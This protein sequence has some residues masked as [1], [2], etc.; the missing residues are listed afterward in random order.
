MRFISRLFRRIVSFVLLLVCI[1]GILYLVPL[2]ERVDT[3][4]LEADAAWMSR[5]PDE[6]RLNEITLPGTHQ[7]ASQFTQ[8]PFFFKC[9]GCSVKSQL[10]SG[11]RFLD[12]HLAVDAGETSTRLKCMNGFVD[13]L[14]EAMPN[15]AKLYLEDVLSQC[16]SFLDEHPTETVLLSIKQERGSE[17]VADFERL[18][19]NAILLNPDR[20]LLTQYIPTLGEAR[21][22]LVLLRR[23][24]DDAG[25]GASSGIPFLWDD[26]G[27]SSNTAL[28]TVSSPNGTYT[29]FVQDRYDYSNDEKWAAFN[30]G[31]AVGSREMANGNISLN[32]LNTNGTFFFGHPHTHAST[33]NSALRNR[34]ENLRGWIVLDFGEPYLA[35]MIYTANNLLPQGQSAVLSG[36]NIGFLP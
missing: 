23:F 34:G 11:F 8:F 29:L 33:L 5:L 10:T 6:T 32:F 17:S 16:Y 12:L 30:N 36:E 15:S 28:N 26:Q 19:F 9:Q 7:S 21:G 18:L 2:T 31:M 35:R 13:C 20:W 14:T 22:R 25:L 27:S 1:F 3:N 24:Q 4:G